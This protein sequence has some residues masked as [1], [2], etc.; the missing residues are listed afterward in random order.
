MNISEIPYPEIYRE[1]ADFRTLLKWFELALSPIQYDTENLIDLL[2]P[3]RC[4]A[5][6]LWMLADTMGYK[7]DERVPTAFNRL[8]LV[9]FMSMIRLRGCRD[10]I[11]LAAEVN[12]AEFNI[13]AYGA[14]NEILFNRLEDTSVPSNSVFVGAHPEHDYIELCYFS[15]RK[16]IDVCLEYVRPVGMYLFQHAGVRM[17]AGNKISVDA[18]LTDQRDLYISIGATRV[19]HYNR[20]DYAS[21]QRASV[22]EQFEGQGPDYTQ[23]RRDLNVDGSHTRKGTWWRNPDFEG[24]KDDEINP[25]FRALSS[26]QLANNEHITRTLIPRTSHEEIEPS[27]EGQIF[28]LGY[29]PQDVDV[30]MPDD[31]LLPLYKDKPVYNLRI[32]RD[33]EEALSSMGGPAPD[34]YTVDRDRSPDIKHPRPGVNPVMAQVGDAIS[35]QPNPTPTHPE[36]L[37]NT[38]YSRHEGDTWETDKP[39][40]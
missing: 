13:E 22:G 38:Y 25:G 26:L 36:A 11:R 34:V 33:M 5:E 12:L 23:T 17:D 14:E 37:E 18:R 10:G 6:L 31:Y 8:V 3:L 32:D 2:D 29:G 30:R 24:Q 1:S 27:A 28:G 16:P 7:Y 9:Y 20:E 21:L 35:I 15:E 4:K 40:D 39:G 19:G